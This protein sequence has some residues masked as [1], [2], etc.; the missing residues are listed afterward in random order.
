[1]YLGHT[2]LRK[3]GKVHRYWRLVR[4]VREGRK[5]IQQTVAHL[6][7]L[8]PRAARRGPSTGLTEV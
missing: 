6:G 4:S 5:V 3:D 8:D 2:T 1:M 7:E